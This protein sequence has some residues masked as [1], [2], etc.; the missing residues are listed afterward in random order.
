MEATQ[1]SG[2]EDTPENL[3]GSLNVF[4]FDQGMMKRCEAKIVPNVKTALP[5]V[6]GQLKAVR[7]FTAHGV[8][9]LFTLNPLRLYVIQRN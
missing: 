5:R 6:A 4:W 9:V 8:G 7:D 1:I 3:A 2:A